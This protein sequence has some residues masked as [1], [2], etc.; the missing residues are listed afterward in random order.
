MNH[1]KSHHTA[2]A[3]FFA[4][5]EPSDRHIS[6]EAAA[7]AVGQPSLTRADPLVRGLFARVLATPA[8]F[9]AP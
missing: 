5:G 8:P 7:D 2:K 3:V 1:E 4:L 9:G 6:R